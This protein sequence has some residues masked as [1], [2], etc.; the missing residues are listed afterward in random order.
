MALKKHI[1][2][3]WRLFIPFVIILWLIVG[4][5]AAWIYYTERQNRIER[6]S[7]QIDLISARIISAYND[8]IDPANFLRF[9]GRYYIENPLYDQ[10]RVSAYYDGKLI[11]NV[12]EKI[13]L[14]DR[15]Q[16]KS[17]GLTSVTDIRSDEPDDGRD[18]FYDVT[19]SDDGRLLVY[20]VLPVDSDVRDAL[21]G[22]YSFYI[23]LLAVAIGGTIL[24]YITSRRLG[25][26]ISILR[27]FALRA[28]S[29]PDFVPSMDFSNDELGDISRQL[30]RFY[31]ERNAAIIKIKREHNVALHALE[32]KTRL[33]RELTNNINHELKTPIGVIKGYID[34][35]RENPDMDPDSRAHFLD[36]TSE[37]VER[38]VQLL[39]DLS[40][41][42]R[43]EFGAQMINLEPINFHEI[44]FQA[45]SDFET[46]GMLGSMTFNYDI[47]TFC[48][49][50]GNEALL[51]G[52][53]N[54][55]TKNAVHYSRGTECNLIL[56]GTDDTYYHFAFYD[57]GVGV[58]PSSLPHLFERF[59]REDSGRS[60]KKGGT[61]LGLPIV[62]NTIEAL[63][64]SISVANRDGGGLLFRFT[65]RKAAKNDT[66]S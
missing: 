42:T 22:S 45:V 6:I 24:T 2:F 15:D 44:V 51:T 62:Q 52:V 14:S 66:R 9:I 3:R 65:L 64:G 63:G 25:H 58:K 37:H 54:N 32:D 19:K 12:G 34:T 39:N 33:K 27:T 28:G 5:V 40:A 8:D 35:L 20:T 50:I 46:S 7:S 48:R 18:F 10:I 30:V 4:A 17:S 49:V 36:K 29:D 53:I 57:N 13:K 11:H 23:F 47:P 55:L 16:L 59:F 41:I 56:T 60:R 21:R 26:D 43:L 38:L 61:G 31:N 1:S